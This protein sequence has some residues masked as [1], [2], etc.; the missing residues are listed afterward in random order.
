M[1]TQSRHLCAQKQAA[2]GT[3]TL[4]HEGILPPHAVLVLMLVL[5]LV[6]DQALFT[7]DAC[8]LK[9]M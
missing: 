1:G 7:R 8:S 3:S 2:V 5:V 9:I 4:P 6:W